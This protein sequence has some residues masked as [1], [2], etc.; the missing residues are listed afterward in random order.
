VTDPTAKYTDKTYSWD[1]QLYRAAGMEPSWTR[2][3]DDGVDVT[4]NDPAT[5]PWPWNPHAQRGG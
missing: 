5:W 1:A 3:W 4:H 2:V